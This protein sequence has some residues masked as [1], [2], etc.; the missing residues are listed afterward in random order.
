MRG[1]VLT[2]GRSVGIA[3]ELEVASAVCERNGRMYVTGFIL[4]WR[5]EYSMWVEWKNRLGGPR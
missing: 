1:K 2:V 5:E 3:V 4:G